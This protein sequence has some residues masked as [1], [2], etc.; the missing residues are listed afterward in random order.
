M[1]LPS[2]VCALLIT[3]LVLSL[4][5][6]ARAQNPSRDL[7]EGARVVRNLDY[8]P[9]GHERQKL[10]LYLPGTGTNWPL[11]VWVHGGA[12]LGGSKENPPALRFLPDGYAIA[13]VNYRLSQH[14]IYPAQLEDC[15]AAIRYLRA[16]SEQHGYNPQLI[17]VW[18]ASAGGHLVALL[19]TTGDV[20][21][22]DVGPWSDHSS[23]VS[24]VVDFFGPSDFLQMEAQDSADG[25]LDHDAPDSPESRLIGG[26]VK[27]PANQ[28]KAT[29]ANPITYITADDP[30]FLIM[31]GEKDNVVPIGQ[32]EL[33]HAALTKAGVSSTFHRVPNAGHGFGGP[34][35]ER[36]VRLF[37][38]QRLQRIASP[39]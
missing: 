20:K 10:D 21:S 13:S 1:K 31:H 32:S 29:R 3:S 16:H 36:R 25:Q 28:Q 8:V 34:E 37:F 17:A 30:P 33:L 22:F 5:G 12:W 9:N 26:P 14:A 24:A 19:G 6:M 39:N 4:F 15:K 23:R 18:G 35:I 7:P 11:I 2:N 27:D 38:E